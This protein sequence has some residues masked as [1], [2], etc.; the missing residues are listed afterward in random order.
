MNDYKYCDCG[1]VYKNNDKSERQKHS[2]SKQHRL[3]LQIIKLENKRLEVMDNLARNF[4]TNL[5]N[6]LEMINKLII[7]N[8]NEFNLIKNK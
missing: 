2:H 4:D 7:E 8:E 1:S 3:Y 5:N 6:Q